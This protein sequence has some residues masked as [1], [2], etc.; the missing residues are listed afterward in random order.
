M[1]AKFVIFI[2]LRSE[3]LQN[4]TGIPM[5]TGIVSTD[6]D[7]IDIVLIFSPGVSVNAPRSVWHVCISTRS[8]AC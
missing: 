1:Y 6:D 7:D 8:P 5:I 2:L 4:N 3:Y